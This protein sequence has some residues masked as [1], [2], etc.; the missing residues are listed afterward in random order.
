MIY[1]S[2]LANLLSKSNISQI[3]SDY[4]NQLRI[5]FEAQY[6]L[7]NFKE[8]NIM[9]ESNKFLLSQVKRIAI[10]RIKHKKG[11]EAIANHTGYTNYQDEVSISDINHN[12][13]LLKEFQFTLYDQE[14]FQNKLI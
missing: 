1:L 8:I 2:Q 13:N 14:L 12:F 3:E 4:A 10:F 7:S 11:I 6:E 9:K 5:Y